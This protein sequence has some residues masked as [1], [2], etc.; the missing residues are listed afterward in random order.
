MASFF[1]LVALDLL[2][3]LLLW[4]YV[5][6]RLKRALELE[7]LLADIRKEVRA[8][9]I[10]LNET[11][12]RNISLLEDRMAA[13]R[14]LLEEADRRIGVMRREVETR[15]A[16]REVYSHL[17]RPRPNA[18]APQAASLGTVA[19]AP[20]SQE[21]AREPI[22]LE[23]AGQA[24]RSGAQGALREQ[25]EAPRGASS[26][27]GASSA[28]APA[29][30]ALVRAAESVIPPRPL[31]EEAAELYRKGF[32]AEL[33]AARLGATVAEVE[34]LVSLEESR[35]SRREAEV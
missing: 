30:P 4:F 16:E 29:I 9:N 6:T 1:T 17:R 18:E 11:A 12:D 28:E 22:R 19:A 31:R 8:L 13:L 27:R 20:P 34:L 33:I 23:L 15:A 25:A 26:E 10:E 24:R 5:R 2:G 14:A 35:A 32:S 21:A 7:G 3:L